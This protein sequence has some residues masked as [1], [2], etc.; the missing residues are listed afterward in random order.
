MSKN[1]PDL[2]QEA[3][4]TLADHQ[5]RWGEFRQAGG[6]VLN[7]QFDNHFRY[8]EGV[9]QPGATV[10]SW[11]QGGLSLLIGYCGAGRDLYRAAYKLY[12]P[13]D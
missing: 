4:K 10:T 3:R 5:E 6:K 2:I 9:L 13:Q 1:D 8:L 12:P 11:L 7:E